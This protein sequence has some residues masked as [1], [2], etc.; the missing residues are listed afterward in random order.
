MHQRNHVVPSESVREYVV[1]VRTDAAAKLLKVSW[2]PFESLLYSFYHFSNTLV[3]RLGSV[4]FVK[5]V[6]KFVE[7]IYT[8]I[9][10]LF[11]L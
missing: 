6:F 2:L 9:C 10:D 7:N 3:A 5:Y 8:A 4:I 11:Q 1:Y